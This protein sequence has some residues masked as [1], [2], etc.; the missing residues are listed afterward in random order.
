MSNFF[1]DLPAQAPPNSVQAVALTFT[2]AQAVTALQMVVAVDDT[3]AKP[4]NNNTTFQNAN[5]LGI[6]QTSANIGQTFT[7]LLFGT[8]TD[9]SFS[10]FQLNQQVFLNSTGFLT[11]SPPS[12]PNYQTTCGKYLGGN[13]ILIT[14][15]NP[16]AL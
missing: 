7:A 15:S 2:A 5:V 16:I 11:Q 9:P 12:H 13:T 1:I 3:T 14:I 8:I 4:G 6:A 10:G